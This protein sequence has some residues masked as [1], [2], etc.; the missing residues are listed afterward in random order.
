MIQHDH[1]SLAAFD[2]WLTRGAEACQVRPAPTLAPPPLRYL[3]DPSA[4]AMTPLACAA[5]SVDLLRAAHGV[6]PG[7][8][9]GLLADEAQ[10]GRVGLSQAWR[11]ALWRAGAA[12]PS[13]LNDESL[14]A[15]PGQS[16]AALRAAALDRAVAAL[17]TQG[18]RLVEAA[19]SA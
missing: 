16:A 7:D 18:W 15:R 1:N 19:E 14:M 6:G 4:S 5:S 13:W 9:L 2:R 8:W 12:S 3:I 10:A 17:W 11:L